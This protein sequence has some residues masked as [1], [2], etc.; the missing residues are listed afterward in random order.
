MIRVLFSNK[1]QPAELFLSLE[2]IAAVEFLHTRRCDSGVHWSEFVIIVR[3]YHLA[4][5]TTKAGA[6]KRL[7]TYTH[8]AW[9]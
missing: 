1:S 8:A 6:F 4:A 9:H 2:F 7:N 5:D 3:L